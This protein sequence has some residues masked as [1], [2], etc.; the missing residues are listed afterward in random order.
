MAEKV[1]LASG[2]LFDS[3]MIIMMEQSR[4]HLLVISKKL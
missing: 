4:V 2:Y 1:I 3:R